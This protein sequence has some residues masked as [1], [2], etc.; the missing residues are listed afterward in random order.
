MKDFVRIYIDDM[1]ITNRTL[2]NHVIYINYIFDQ[3]VEYNIIIKGSK[4][5]ISYSS[6]II[7]DQRVD[8]YSLLITKDR[9]TILSKITF[10]KN[11]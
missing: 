6:A 4:C 3:F 5:F 10:P 8:I 11:M 9:F 1:V 7:L 2:K